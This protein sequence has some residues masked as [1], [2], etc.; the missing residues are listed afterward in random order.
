MLAELF[1]VDHQAAEVI[2]KGGTGQE[3]GQIAKANGMRSLAE[4]G[5]SLAGSGMVNVQ[6][7]SQMADW[8]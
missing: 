1:E 4:E 6:E 8:A 7:M 3:L 5:M 2:G